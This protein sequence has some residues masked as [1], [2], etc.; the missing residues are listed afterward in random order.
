MGCGPWCA[1]RT[2]DHAVISIHMIYRGRHKDIVF[3]FLPVEGQSK[4]TIII[5]EGLPSV[6]RR[7]ETLET[8]KSLGFDVVFPRY[9]GTW[10]SP[11]EFLAD[12]PGKDI[13]DIVELV[14]GGE[15]TELYGGKS[16]EVNKKVFLIAS[17][18]GGGV[19]MS[20][21]E[22]EDIEGVVALSPVVD[23]V[24]HNSEGGETDLFELIS[25][26]RSAFGEGY[27]FKD[28]DWQKMAK[29]ELFNP[30]QKLDEDTAKKLFVVYDDSDTSVSE[31]AIEG[32][33]MRNGVRTMKTEGLGHLSFSKVDR[34]MWQN[35]LS[36]A[37][38]L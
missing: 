14:K 34:E 37:G 32:Y 18:F 15:L 1:L 21:I 31:R 30:P 13:L 33:C 7:H 27:R 3:E 38:L 36:E 10:E 23:F 6:P 22:N 4:G 8:L 2:T 20:V 12:S 25:F 35:V 19:A 5:C 9:R 17:S 28:E 26:M 24:S 16:F 29:G 11:G